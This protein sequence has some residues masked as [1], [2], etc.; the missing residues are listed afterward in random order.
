[1]VKRIILAFEEKENQLKNIK[2]NDDNE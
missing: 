1:L 2:K